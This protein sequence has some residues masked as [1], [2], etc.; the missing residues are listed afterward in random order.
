MRRVTTGALVLTALC[1]LPGVVFASEDRLGVSAN[2]ASLTD[3]DGG[4]GGSLSW[5]HNFDPDAILGVAAEHQKLGVSR[6]TFGTLNGALSRGQGDQRYTFA[7]EAHEG[8]GSD[9]GKHFNYAIEA[10]SVTGTYFHRFNLQVEDKQI[11]VE[12]TH[13]NLP[14]I[15]LAYLVNPHFQMQ[16]SYSY[17]FG[18]N[19]GTRLPAVRIDVYGSRV[20]FLAGGAWGTVSPIVLGVQTV[21]PPRPTREGYA[22]L[23][24]PLPQWRSDVTV[25]ADYLYLR[26][27]S[28]I[29][30]EISPLP[31]TVRNSTKLT[32]TVSW[33]YHVGAKK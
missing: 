11:N 7:A 2:G 10:L 33:I 6:W 30:T 31:Q 28:F 15:G 12:T 14:K 24:I 17:S 26:G 9:N 8:A 27:G 13:G 1:V 5:L 32:G 18:G 20:N 21:L 23:S 29:D 25:L 19:L 16:A 22:G 4:Y 3:T